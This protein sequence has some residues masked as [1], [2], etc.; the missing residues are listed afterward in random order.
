MAYILDQNCLICS[1]YFSSANEN[2]S[3]RNENVVAIQVRETKRWSGIKYICGTG[4]HRFSFPAQ[5]VLCSVIIPDFIFPLCTCVKERNPVLSRR[6]LIPYRKNQRKLQ[7]KSDIS[8]RE[9]TDTLT[10]IKPALYP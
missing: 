9:N 1:L 6:L 2:S 10:F 8:A 7:A 4:Q 3:I 5:S